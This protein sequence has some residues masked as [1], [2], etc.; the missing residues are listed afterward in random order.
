MKIFNQ[1]S[2]QKYNRELKK[3]FIIYIKSIKNFKKNLK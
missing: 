2:Y 3:K 1:F